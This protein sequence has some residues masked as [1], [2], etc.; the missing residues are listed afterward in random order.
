MNE[1]IEVKRGPGRPPKPRPEAEAQ[2]FYVHDQ[3]AKVDQSAPE[4]HT[5]DVSLSPDAAPQ[6][7]ESLQQ[8]IDRVRGMRR[9]FGAFQLKLA[10]DQRPGYHRHWFNDVPGRVDEALASGWTHVMKDGKPISRVVGTGRDNGVLRAFA[11]EIPLVFWEEDMAARHKAA[12]AKIDTI[13][14][15]PFMSRSGESKP[16]D[17]G[18]FYSPTEAAP[19]QVVKA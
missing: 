18:K 9:P 5:A 4:S 10:I 3:A 14:E 11:M 8:A 7:E 16:A 15:K 12:Q 13:K 6:G 1:S 19:L 2:P 17:Q